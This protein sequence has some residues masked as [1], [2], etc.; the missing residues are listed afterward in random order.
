MKLKD[1][2]QQADA[3]DTDLG[4]VEVPP[5]VD[6]RTFL[7]RNAAIGAAAVMTGGID[8][9]GWDSIPVSV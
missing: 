6:R 3:L 8:T 7:M 5:G 2:G 1:P 4:S 9:R